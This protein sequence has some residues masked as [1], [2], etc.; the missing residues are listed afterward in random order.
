MGLFFNKRKISNNK[1]QAENESL[2]MQLKQFWGVIYESEKELIIT[3]RKLK[4]KIYKLEHYNR[5][6]ERDNNRLLEDN[7]LLRKHLKSIINSGV[8]KTNLI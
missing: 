8:E 3:K 6:L 7:K 5:N 2:K 4:K 1:E